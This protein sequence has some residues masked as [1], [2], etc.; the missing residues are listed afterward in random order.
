V[1]GVK[2]GIGDLTYCDAASSLDGMTVRQVL[3]AANTAL[4]GGGFPSGYNA[5][6]M[7]QLVEALNVAFNSCSASVFAQ[8]YLCP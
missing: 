7:R 5:I 8:S 4:G 1:G 6:S 2:G 3:A